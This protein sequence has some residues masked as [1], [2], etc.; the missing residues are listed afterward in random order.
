MFADV[1]ERDLRSQTNPMI[2]CLEFSQELIRTNDRP[3][4]QRHNDVMLSLSVYFGLR[5]FVLP[6]LCLGHGPS[7]NHCLHLYQVCL[8]SLV[9][10]LFKSVFSLLFVVSI[11]IIFLMF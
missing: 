2:I 4:T 8:H 6:Y 7:S 9:M 11:F 3:I 5:F 10:L 1:P